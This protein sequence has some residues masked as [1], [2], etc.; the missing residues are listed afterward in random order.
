MIL[1]RVRKSVLWHLVI[2]FGLIKFK[3]VCSLLFV[4]TFGVV[5]LE[6]LRLTQI[7]KEKEKEV[8]E[9]Y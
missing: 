3:F 8:E 7:Q 2:P 6:W 9:K 5:H 1:Q 4:Y